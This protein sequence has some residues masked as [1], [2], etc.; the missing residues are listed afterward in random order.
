MSDASDPTR[1]SSVATADESGLRA[2]AQSMLGTVAAIQGAIESAMTHDEPGP[3]RD[4][5]LLM[6]TRRLEFL[7]RQLRDI[8]AG[9]P[10]SDV[11]LDLRT[12]ENNPGDDAR[13]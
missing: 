10:G 11:V 2:V 3:G 1:S 9:V 4:S 8:A 5:L 13:A 6:A 7:T 12:S